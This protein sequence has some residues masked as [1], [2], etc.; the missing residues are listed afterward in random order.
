M[1][2][3]YI[4]Q[5]LREKKSGSKLLLQ[6][7]LSFLL[8]EVGKNNRKECTYEAN[9]KQSILISLIVVKIRKL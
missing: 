1:H 8:N 9:I 2:V 6:L 4:F 5:S 3:S 7:V